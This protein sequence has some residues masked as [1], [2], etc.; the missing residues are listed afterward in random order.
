MYDHCFRYDLMVKCWNKR[1]VN[2]PRFSELVSEIST[3][4]DGMAG[5][6]ELSI[7]PLTA[8]ITVSAEQECAQQ[9]SDVKNDLKAE[10]TV[11]RAKN[12]YC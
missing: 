4:L 5:Y 11:C 1:P 10:E 12:D 2:R 8:D 3:S 9:D 6:M 7:E